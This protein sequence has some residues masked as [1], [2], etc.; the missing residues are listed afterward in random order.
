[1]AVRSAI[2]M[3]LSEQDPL[4]LASGE[5]KEKLR[6]SLKKSVNDV[7]TIKEGFGG[8][9]EVFFTSFVTQ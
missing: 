4:E 8:I 1:M 9:E 7:L 2:L 6:Q 5:G 3:R